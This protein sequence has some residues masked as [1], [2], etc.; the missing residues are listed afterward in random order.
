MI[1]GEFFKSILYKKSLRGFLFFLKENDDSKQ[2]E[3]KKKGI[4]RKK[5]F[6]WWNPFSSKG[7]KKLP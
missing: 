4:E 6:K 2:K 7:N 5:A 1:F 3:S